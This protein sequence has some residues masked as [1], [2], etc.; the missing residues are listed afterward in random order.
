MVA[1]YTP[2]VP[3]LGTMSTLSAAGFLL[4]GGAVIA[5]I[6]RRREK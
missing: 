3:A 6:R 1:G 2:M 4:L 5:F